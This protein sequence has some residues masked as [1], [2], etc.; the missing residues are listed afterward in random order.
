MTN[1]TFT[2]RSAMPVPAD[3]LYAWHGRPLAFQ[4]LQPPWEHI[5]ITS[6][7]GSFGTDGYRVEFRTSFLG[8]IKGTWVADAYDFQPGQHFQDRQVHGP[9]AYWN[10]RHNFIPDGPVGSILEDSI[11]YRLPLG[12]MGRLFGAGMVRR[13][14][15][16]VF[17]YRHALTASDL[18]RH[19]LYR[20][21]PRLTIA[22]TGSRGLVGSELV[23]FLTTGGHRVVRLVSGKGS[24]RHDDGTKWVSWEPSARLDPQVL[25]GV[26][27]VIHLAGDNVAE[28]RWT[29]AKKKRIED[30]RTIPTRHLAE[31]IAALP[32]DRRP[33]TFVCASAVGFYGNRGDEPL[34]EASAP[35]SGFFPHVCKL[36]EEAA[37]PAR[38]AGVRTSHL[39][40]GVV[41]T[42]RGAA[43]GK[44]LLAFESG[45]GAVL[46]SGR[47]WTSWITI[48]DLVGALHHCLMNGNVTGPVNGTAPHPVT[49]KE[50]TKTLGKVL[51]RPAV[52]WLPA[53]ALRLMFGELADDALL[54]S[55]KVLPNRLLE[56]GFAFD[57]SELLPALDFLLG[58]RV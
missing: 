49:N 25:D 19:S 27:A 4:R 21:R 35:G 17:A 41:L 28:G 2:F 22:V 12:M 40:I 37:A 29:A 8:P 52:L 5:D 54:A 26:D 18:K 55:M 36:W 15:Q 32:A 30:S 51:H 16:S 20:D 38:D 57:H 14:L 3:E 48:G 6:T 31:A 47:Q 11:E 23:P 53:P 1:A 42:P 13:K 46:G 7:S 39:R 58:R 50:F 24:P 43:L 56:T 44:Q 9:F 45:A 34:T 10:H 33:R